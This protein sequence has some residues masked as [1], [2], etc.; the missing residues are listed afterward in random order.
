MGHRICRRDIRY[1]KLREKNDRLLLAICQYCY[2]FFLD[3]LDAGAESEGASRCLVKRT[4][5]KWGTNRK[6]GPWKERTN[7]APKIGNRPLAYD[8]VTNLRRQ[9]IFKAWQINAIIECDK[10][11]VA[12]RARDWDLWKRDHCIGRTSQQLLLWRPK[13]SLPK[14]VPCKHTQTCWSSA[15]ESQD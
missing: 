2:T 6:K 14:G 11:I 5:P 4:W 8:F 9:I 3:F 12:W 10:V 15:C 13:C 7:N 1:W